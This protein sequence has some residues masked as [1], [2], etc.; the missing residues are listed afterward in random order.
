MLPPKPSPV[1]PSVWRVYRPKPEKNPPFLSSPFL[2]PDREDEEG[3]AAPSPPPATDDGSRTVR[4]SGCYRL[5]DPHAMAVFLP[6][7][8][9]EKR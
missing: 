3:E 5:I 7:G 6:V 1:G 9:C 4:G 2:P 8:V